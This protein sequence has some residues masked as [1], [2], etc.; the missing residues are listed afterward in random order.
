MRA[1]TTY[2]CIGVK[3]WIF[4]GEI[5]GGMAQAMQPTPVEDTKPAKKRGGREDREDR[6]GRGGREDR[7]GRNTEAKG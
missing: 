6:G 3:V 1:E 2:G 7:G 4:K 5:L